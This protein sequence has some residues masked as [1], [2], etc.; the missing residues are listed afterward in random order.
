MINNKTASLSVYK[1]DSPTKDI[2]MDANTL[3]FY[4]DVEELT[5]L[6]KNVPLYSDMEL[7]ELRNFYLENLHFSLA[8]GDILWIGS[9]KLYLDYL[10]K[11]EIKPLN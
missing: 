6:T 10:S 2:I 7:E 1:G 4:L 11:L 8:E 3:Q 9:Y 5:Y